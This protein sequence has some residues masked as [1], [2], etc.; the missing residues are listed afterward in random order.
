[1]VITPRA[2]VRIET[3]MMQGSIEVLQSLLVQE[4]GL[5]LHAWQHYVSSDKITP[6]AGVRI[7]TMHKALSTPSWQITPRAGV[8]IETEYHSFVSFLLLSL[9]VQECGLKLSVG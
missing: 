7:E 4:C 3:G 6:R 1:M 9:L 2:G 5:K 8:R